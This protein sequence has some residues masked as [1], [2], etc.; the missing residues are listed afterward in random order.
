M[1]GGVTVD[2][3]G[4]TSMPGLWAAGEVTSSGLHGANRLASNSLLE[5]L[6]YGAYAGEAASRSAAERTSDLVALPIHH[7]SAEGSETFDVADV[8]VSLKSLMGR[9]AGVERNEPGLR[10]AADSIRSFA[11]YVMPHQFD[12]IEGW[13]LQNLLQTSAC[14]V[15]AA[16]IRSESR[17]VHFRE[18]FPTA[19]HRQWRRHLTIQIDVNGGHPQ[20]GKLLDPSELVPTEM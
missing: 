6:V 7:P 4:R 10:E 13:E 14:M 15:D 5:G 1:I 8:R 17:G 18:D 16:L 2:R 9:L 3:Q 12:N 20:A 11:A 19:D